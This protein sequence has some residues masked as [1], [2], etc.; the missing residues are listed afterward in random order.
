[1][2]LTDINNKS[3][4][5][6]TIDS[7]NYIPGIQVDF[8]CYDHTSTNTLYKNNYGF[9]STAIENRC[10][11]TPKKIYSQRRAK[12]LD[13]SPAPSHHDRSSPDRRVL[14]LVRLPPQ[15]GASADFCWILHKEQHLEYL[16]HQGDVYRPDGA[17][18]HANTDRALS[19]SPAHVNKHA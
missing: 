10:E 5:G 4:S 8:S 18:Q 11:W 12:P 3:I 16:L 2:E 19:T 9:S 7:Y 15:D 1:M 17:S 14:L 6:P 13:H